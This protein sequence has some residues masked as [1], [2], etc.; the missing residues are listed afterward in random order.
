MWAALAVEPAGAAHEAPVAFYATAEFWV[1]IGFIILLALIGKRAYRLVIVSLDERAERIRGRIDETARLAEEAQA[2]LATYERKQRDAAGEAEQIL[3]DSRR[4]VDRLTE[5]AAAELER[6]LRRR[7]EMAIERISQAEA[8]AVAEVRTRAVDVAIEA[9]Q[10][11]ITA[12]MTPKQSDA[13]IDAAI[14]ELPG[15]LH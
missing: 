7:E 8:A 6:S 1:A 12:K 13:L 2:L 11:L 15:K 3:A 10:R 5:H 14:A 9:T 4:E